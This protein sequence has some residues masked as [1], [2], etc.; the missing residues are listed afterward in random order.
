M[1]LSALHNLQDQEVYHPQKDKPLRE[2]TPAPLAS[3]DA[4][5]AQYDC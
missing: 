4:V 2:M 5:Q 3:N 1:S